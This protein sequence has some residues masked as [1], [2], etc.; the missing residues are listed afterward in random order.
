MKQA[1]W[2]GI[3]SATEQVPQTIRWQGFI[4]NYLHR[5]L[6]NS[7][8]KSIDRTTKVTVLTFM[9]AAGADI[10]KHNVQRRRTTCDLSSEQI[11]SFQER[12]Y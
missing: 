5:S 1:C 11:T 2:I 10:I 6:A 9:S 3:E 4:L 12:I 8:K 7:L